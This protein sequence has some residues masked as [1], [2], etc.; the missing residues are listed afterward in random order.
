MKRLKDQTIIALTAIFLT[1]F[2][3][4]TTSEKQPQPPTEPEEPGSFFDQTGGKPLRQVRTGRG[5]AA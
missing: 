2:P 3:G 4:C 5:C 1:L